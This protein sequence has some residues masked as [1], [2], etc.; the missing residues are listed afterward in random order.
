MIMITI[1]IYVMKI[2]MYRTYVMK[3]NS[4]LALQLKLSQNFMLMKKTSS[5]PLL[6]Q[7]FHWTNRNSNVN[8]NFRNELLL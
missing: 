1:M 7:V 2:H 8:R 6:R 4:L 3:L 5:V